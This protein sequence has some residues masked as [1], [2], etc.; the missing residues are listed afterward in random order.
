MLYVIQFSLHFTGCF[1]NDIFHDQDDI[2]NAHIAKC[3]CKDWKHCFYLISLQVITKFAFSHM[4]PY[5]ISIS[6]S[7]QW[8]HIFN[9]NIPQCLLY[10]SYIRTQSVNANDSSSPVSGFKYSVP[11]GSV[12]GPLLYTIYNLPLGDLLRKAGIF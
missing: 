12:L 4:F 1:C 7:I 6:Y 10:K 5:Q 8:N 2:L 9:I 3:N 11:Q